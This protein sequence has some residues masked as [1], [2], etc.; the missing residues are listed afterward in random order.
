[1][2]TGGH[3]YFG[4][5]DSDPRFAAQKGY[6]YF[7]LENDNWLVVGLDTAWEA[8][9]FKGDAGGLQEP[10]LEWLLRLRMYAPGKRLLLLSHHQLF[11]LYENDSPLLQ[12]RI[13]PLLSTG[14]VDAWFW[15]HEH[16]CAVYEPSHQ[17]TYPVV[18]GH[19]GVPVPASKTA[20]PQGVRYEYRCKRTGGLMQ[21]FAMMGFIVVDLDGK[22][23]TVRFVN[24]ENVQHTTH[25]I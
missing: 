2:F 5:L 14:P 16:R 11:S 9:G 6:S 20:Q 10:Q 17:V 21:S 4:C 13:G 15:G 12:Q 23:A 22:N 18:M 1:M 25:S 8:E 3:G 7:A 24:E 19:A